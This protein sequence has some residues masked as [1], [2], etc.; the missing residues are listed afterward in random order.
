MGSSHQQ[1]PNGR[2]LTTQFLKL[3]TDARHACGYEIEDD[4]DAT[5]NPRVRLVG[6]VGSSSSRDVE[7]AST[8]GRGT[9]GGGGALPAWV[10]ASEGIREEMAACRGSLFRL[11]E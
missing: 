8:S 7:M 2:N 4:E 9:G 11:K 10:R 6:G 3:R 5:D 1:P